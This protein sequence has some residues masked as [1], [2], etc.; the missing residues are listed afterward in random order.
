VEQV[1]DERAAAGAAA[2]GGAPGGAALRLEKRTHLHRVGFRG[3]F[4]D[5]GNGLA[6]VGFGFSSAA[7]RNKGTRGQSE[8]RLDNEER[9]LRRARTRLRH[10]VLG[11]GAAYM[12]TLTYRENITDF[13]RASEDLNVFLRW[14]AQ[15]V[16][17]TPSNLVR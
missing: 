14:R 5:Y 7:R 17:A 8:N 2:A 1:A 16:S 6:E 15:P 11:S 12:L 4:V 9:A 3:R 10:L 13:E